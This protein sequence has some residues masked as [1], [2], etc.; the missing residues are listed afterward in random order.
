MCGK[1]TQERPVYQK[2]YDNKGNLKRNAQGNLI[3]KPVPRPE[4]AHYFRGDK[5]CIRFD[6]FQVDNMK[7]TL[8]SGTRGSGYFFP[9]SLI[10]FVRPSNPNQ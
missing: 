1:V 3:L 7:V 5:I 6:P 8:I 9:T 2:S 10:D 4:V